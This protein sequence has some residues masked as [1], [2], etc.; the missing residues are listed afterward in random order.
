MSTADLIKETALNLFAYKG[1]EGTSIGNIAKEVGIKKASIYSH[2]SSK[3]ELYISIFEEVLEWDE[4]YFTGLLEKNNKLCVKD[5]FELIFKYYCKI[6]QEEPYRTKMIFLNRAMIFPTDFLKEKKQNIF[7]DNEIT[8]TPIISSLIQEGFESKAIKD[9]SIT[10]ILSFFYCTVDGLFVE[11][12]YYSTED[13]NRK[14]ESI[15]KLFWQTIK[16]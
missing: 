6:Y 13:F 9:Y 15:W 14:A 5:K 7:K 11:S 3:E 12:C 4:N 1:Y 2:I 10:E 8:F 16:A